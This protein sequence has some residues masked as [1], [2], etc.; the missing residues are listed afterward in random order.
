MKEGEGR[1]EGWKAKEGKG[2]KEGEGGRVKEGKKEGTGKKV[3]EGRKK[4]KGR[5]EGCLPAFMYELASHCTCL[6]TDNDCY[7]PTKEGN[8]GRNIKERN[9]GRK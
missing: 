4:G 2:R 5:Q 1:K 3:K 6:S 7:L 9:K 8:K